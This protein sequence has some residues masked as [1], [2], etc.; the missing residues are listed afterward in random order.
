MKVKYSLITCLCLMLASGLCTACSEDIQSPLHPVLPEDEDL[1]L[2]G[3]GKFIV[4]YGATE[5]STT[6]ALSDSL[7]A[8]ERISSLHYFVYEKKNGELIKQRT[9]RGINKDTKWPIDNRYDMPWELRQ[10]LQD[11]L[12]A[13]YDYRI[14][15]IAN[16]DPKL[17]KKKDGSEHPALLRDEQNYNSA[18]LLLPEVP[19]SDNNMFY[20]W[21]GELINTKPGETVKRNDVL[22]RRLVTR[23]DVKRMGIENMDKY[24]EEL[25]YKYLYKDSASI[26]KDFNLHLDTFCIAMPKIMDGDYHDNATKLSIYLNKPEIREKLY[27][28]FKDNVTEKF[29]T[30]LKDYCYHKAQAWEKSKSVNIGYEAQSRCNALNFARNGLNWDQSAVQ[31]EEILPIE[32]GKFTIVGFW[33]HHVGNNQL[34]SL[35]FSDGTKTTLEMDASKLITKKDMNRWYDAICNPIDIIEITEGT[36]GYTQELNFET[37]L[38]GDQT[39]EECINYKSSLTSSFRK[40]VR[41]N[42]FEKKS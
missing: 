25:I 29:T 14:L 7:G 12:V 6:R 41:I 19:F 26:K 21:E 30:A 18:K 4:N 17:F 35:S 38:K 42:V 36:E 22:L 34:S 15:F 24:I 1:P 13:N 16:I 23:T 5:G 20:L 31:N 8:S 32:G 2:A 11:T 9:I 39:W 28:A 3:D 37:I 40:W 27:N 33:G 10:D